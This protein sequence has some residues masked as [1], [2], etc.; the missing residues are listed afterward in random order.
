MHVDESCLGLLVAAAICVGII[1]IVLGAMI[2]CPDAWLPKKEH[3]MPR[4]PQH[5]RRG[6]TRCHVSP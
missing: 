6:G 3:P 4:R 2:L 5:V 1:L